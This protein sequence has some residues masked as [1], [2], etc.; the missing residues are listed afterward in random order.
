MI[1]GKIWG[2]TQPLFD[3]NNVE[4]H[5]IHIK[6]GHVCSLHHHNHRKNGFFVVLGRLMIETHKNDY[7]LIDRTVLGPNQLTESNP[8]EKHR[9]IALED[10]VAV[11]WYWVELD[12]DDIERA[13][14]GQQLPPAEFSRL[15]AIA[16]EAVP[17]VVAGQAPSGIQ[18]LSQLTAYPAPPAAPD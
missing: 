5:I 4:C 12:H 11:E 9:F 13:D 3:H 2:S 15:L 6:R 18:A 8:G 14:H 7:E 16:N 17:Q 1:K 10:T